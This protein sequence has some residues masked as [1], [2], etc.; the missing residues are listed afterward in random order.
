MTENKVYTRYKNLKKAEIWLENY[1]AKSLEKANPKNKDDIAFYMKKAEEGLFG[2]QGNKNIPKEV[3]QV[4]RQSRAKGNNFQRAG[5]SFFLSLAVAPSTL[6]HNLDAQ[7]KRDANKRALKAGLTPRYKNIPANRSLRIPV[8]NQ[9][10]LTAGGNNI[11]ALLEAIRSDRYTTEDI[12]GTRNA[13]DVD[14]DALSG[15]KLFQGT[16]DPT[17][18]NIYH[19]DNFDNVTYAERKKNER[20]LFS[21]LQKGNASYD[22]VFYKSGSNW[23][24]QLDKSSPNYHLNKTKST[25]N[26]PL[27][28]S[29][30]TKYFGSQPFDMNQGDVP[31]SNRRIRG[32]KQANAE[33]RALLISKGADE[34]QVNR[35]SDAVLSRYRISGGF[36]SDTNIQ[37]SNEGR[38]PVS[39]N[40]KLNR[41]S[42]NTPG[43]R[44]Y[45]GTSASKLTVPPKEKV[46]PKVDPYKDKPLGSRLQFSDPL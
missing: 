23:R 41:N 20:Q 44:V 12:L 13:A 30:Q 35:L 42:L 9:S 10:P 2:R 37:L 19:M 25:S 3:L 33:T 46:V 24:S 38:G 8:Q 16:W 36:E 45:E 28:I 31:W 39:I 1:I 22:N 5:S 17:G 27:S 43:G 15:L 6:I 11:V 4:I 7:S 14:V 32:P 26:D 21:R 29:K 40:L 18:T 34:K